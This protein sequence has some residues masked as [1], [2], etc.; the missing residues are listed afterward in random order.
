LANNGDTSNLCDGAH[1]NAFSCPIASSAGQNTCCLRTGSTYASIQSQ[2]YSCLQ[3][4]W[5][6][7]E[8][9]P[10]NPTCGSTNGHWCNMRSTTFKYASCGFA[11]TSTGKLWMNQDFT[12][13]LPSG[14]PAT[15]TCTTAGASDGC[16]GI[17]VDSGASPTPA[18]TA[19]P[20]P[21]PTAGPTPTRAPTAGP[22]PAPTA[23]P[24]PTR[25]PTAGPTPAPTASPPTGSSSANDNSSGGLSSGKLKRSNA[26]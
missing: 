12:A 25:A 21:A 26:S 11:Y 14:V 8:G 7:G 16:G 19:G 5:D 17:C 3:Q 4:M 24:T 10:A 22:T 18:P 1:T 23:G 15:C 9:Q 20:T 6:E 2:L 13:G